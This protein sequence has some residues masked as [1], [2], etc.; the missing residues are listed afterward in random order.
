MIYLGCLLFGYCLGFVARWIWDTYGPVR[1]PP[2]L[3][4]FM[5]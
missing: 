2:E 3:E 1:I 4:R 5:R